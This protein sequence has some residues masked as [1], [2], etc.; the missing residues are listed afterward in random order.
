MGCWVSDKIE[1]CKLMLF[2][3]ASFAG[4][5]RDSKSTSNGYLCIAGPKTYVPVIWTCKKQGAVSHSF[6]EA[7]VIALEAVTRMEG[8]S[9]QV[10]WDTALEVFGSSRGKPHAQ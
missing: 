7:E 5:L 6:S 4:D 1:D 9:A 8:V 3:D 2:S 10:L